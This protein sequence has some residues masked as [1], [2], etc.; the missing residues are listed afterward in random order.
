MKADS[1]LTCATRDMIDVA[2]ELLQTW[3]DAGSVYLV[4]VREDFEHA[5]ERI[6]GAHHHPLKELDPH[7]LRRI[8]DGK[9][10]VFHCRSGKR[11][12]EAA[13]RF[14]EVSEQSF[15][16]NGGIES[17]K[18]AGLPT[19]RHPTAPKIDVMRQVQLTAGMLVLTGVVLGFFVSPWFLM[20]SGLIG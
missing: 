11:S 7:A 2:P 10:V 17:W 4:D 19:Q 8:S 12:T 20:L 6:P 18:A 15:H 13:K 9:R 3:L 5:A 1:N 16:I 14:H